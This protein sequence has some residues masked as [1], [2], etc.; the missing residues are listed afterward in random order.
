MAGIF[1]LEFHGG[2]LF[3]HCGQFADRPPDSSDRGVM[4][5]LLQKPAGVAWIET[6]AAAMISIL[7]LAFSPS[8]G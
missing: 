4:M 1:H 6:G 5:Q 3:G 7:E 2:R 8:S